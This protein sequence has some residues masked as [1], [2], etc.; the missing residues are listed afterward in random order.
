MSQSSS[1]RCSSTVQQAAFLP[2]LTSATGPSS[3]GEGLH[4]LSDHLQHQRSSTPPLHKFST[5]SSPLV[6]SF[7]PSDNCTANIN[8]GSPTMRG[9]SY[10]ETSLS[11]KATGAPRRTSE[12]VGP[13]PPPPT[14]PHRTCSSSGAN[15]GM[16][17][18]EGKQ[19]LLEGQQVKCSQEGSASASSVPSLP[20]TSGVSVGGGS[21]SFTR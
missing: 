5:L 21:S 20:T 16:M 17:A 14:P 11:G 3:L 8:G 15:G 6:T 2:S 13:R 19:L 9:Y 7:L 4:L 10:N 1:T 18:G 12:V